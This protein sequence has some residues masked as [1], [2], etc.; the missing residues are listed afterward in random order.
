MTSSGDGAG[1][2]VCPGGTISI[3]GIVVADRITL[4]RWLGQQPTGLIAA[5]ISLGGYRPAQLISEL[6]AQLGRDPPVDDSLVPVPTGGRPDIAT[7]GGWVD[8]E[9]HGDP[10]VLQAD[11]AVRALVPALHDIATVLVAIPPEPTDW[12][13]MDFWTLRFLAAAAESAGFRLVLMA[14]I[15]PTP[16]LPPL[17]VADWQILPS[18]TD[19]ISDSITLLD[20]PPTAYWLGLIPGVISPMLAHAL[21]FDPDQARYL[22]LLPSGVGLVPPELRAAARN[23]RD[24]ET[25]AAKSAA[26]PWIAAYAATLAPEAGDQRIVLAQAWRAFGVGATD[27]AR[28]LAGRGVTM[29]TE[30]AAR[31]NAIFSLQSIRI[32]CQDYDGLAETTPSNASAATEDQQRDLDWFRGWGHALRGETQQA[33]ELFG[34][35]P[36]ETLL[37]SDPYMDLYMRNITALALHRGGNT[38]IALSVEHDIDERLGRLDTP[39]I[40]LRYLNALNLS[41]LYSA[42]GQPME[43][44]EWLTQVEATT[45]G[46][47]L[48]SDLL[49]FQLLRARLADDAGKTVGA[50]GHWFAAA[51]IFAALPRPEALNWRVAALIGGGGRASG[52]DPD[53]MATVLLRHIGPS[54][55]MYNAGSAPNFRL[56]NPTPTAVDAMAIGGPGW[57]LLAVNDVSSPAYESNAHAALRRQLATTIGHAAPTY[58]VDIRHGR[59]LPETLA[60]LAE[61]ALWHDVKELVWGGRIVGLDSLLTDAIQRLELSP[62][63]AS[64]DGDTVYFKRYRPPFVMQAAAKDVLT[65]TGQP[66][67]MLSDEEHAVAGQ[68]VSEGV[69]SA[70]LHL[71]TDAPKDG[72]MGE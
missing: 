11:R 25:L 64:I 60:A 10:A 46:V 8:F 41:R 16:V 1:Y 26:I 43:A 66:I 62:G 51:M 6:A 36:S 35:P 28:E 61:I 57:G 58:I 54:G 50:H 65:Q 23:G 38:A 52:I 5:D 59:G 17:L 44:M 18:M 70:V 13:A 33:L 34:G 29:A 49:H 48:P 63:V 71:G 47:A 67:E 72:A 30:D 21:G 45:L 3:D 53:A 69:L 42:T 19:D 4:D 15:K 40:H 55:S 56:A 22:L 14:S 20:P 68:L 9:S 31:L 7:V 24:A 12:R 39:S 32:A 27:L 2:L 37:D